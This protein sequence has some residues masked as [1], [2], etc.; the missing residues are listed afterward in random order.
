MELEKNDLIL[1]MSYV[2]STLFIKIHYSMTGNKGADPTFQGLPVIVSCSN[3][4][5]W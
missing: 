3:F 1:Y 4:G 2:T 5:I